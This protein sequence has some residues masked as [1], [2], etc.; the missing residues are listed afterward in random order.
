MRRAKTPLDQDA[1]R[2]ANDAVRKETG[3]RQ[4]TMGPEDAA[5]RTKWMDAYIKAAGPNSY[6][7]TK[8]GHKKPAETIQKCPYNE[9][10]FLELQYSYADGAGVAGALYVV[11]DLDTK[12]IVAKGTLDNEGYAYVPIPLATKRIDYNF[13]ND[14]PKVTYLIKPQLT[15]LWQV[16]ADWQERVLDKLNATADNVRTAINSMDKAL[17]DAKEW[18][19]GVLQGDFNENPQLSQILANMIVTLIPG[20]DQVGDLRDLIAN[21]KILIYDKRYDE[22]AAWFALVVTI[23]GAFPE[24]GSLAK[25][26]IKTIVKEAKA[27][28]K[29][30]IKKLIEVFNFFAKG[31]SVKYLREFSGKLTECATFVKSKLKAV[32][33]EFISLINKAIAILP[34]KQLSEHAKEIKASAEKVLSLVDRQVDKEIKEIQAT[35]D[36]SVKESADFTKGGSTKTINERHQI[37]QFSSPDD[38]I[39]QHAY[40]KHKYDPT[41]ISTKYRTQYGENIDPIYIRNR[42]FDEPDNIEKLVDKNGVHYATK[43]SKKFDYNIS[44]NDT[45]TG[46]S[47]VIIN[48]LNSAD[49]TQFPYYS[50]SK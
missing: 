15:P 22:A 43:Y 37:A 25:G 19:W 13:Y 27:S 8:D 50:N 7:S 44:T 10:N 34:G 41:K 4:L 30:P 39:S 35:L 45:P 33:N 42:T 38:F 46:D 40:E 26:L 24:L 47:R 36:Q 28:N 23:I 3:G 1:V 48:H 12:G 5:L 20:V 18:T 31:N 11:R 32:L 49:S 9:K 16:T 6:T 2:Q 17:A 29:V 14:P 21:L